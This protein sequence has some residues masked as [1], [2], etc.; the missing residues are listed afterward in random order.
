MFERFTDRARKV[1]AFANQEAQRY[2]H[3][4]I[5][6]EHIL[7]GLL[8]EGKGAAANALNQLDVDLRAARKAVE[9]IVEPGPEM[10]TMGKLPQTPNAKK[11]IEQAI[12]AAKELHANYVGTEH[13]LLGLTRVPDNTALRVL[14]KLGLTGTDVRD[15][16][17]E[18]LGF[19]NETNAPRPTESPEWSMTLEFAVPED[20]DRKEANR[21]VAQMLGHLSQFQAA[22]GGTGLVIRDGVSYSPSKVVEHVGGCP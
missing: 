4:Y 21:L 19:D 5:G 1:M 16:V 2:D 22:L 20:V 8:K 10:V 6:C 7:L 15:K 11:S 9:K 3:E 17:L 13:V 12:A 14:E 18:V